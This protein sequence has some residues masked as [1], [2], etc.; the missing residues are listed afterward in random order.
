MPP[1]KTKPLSGLAKT[2]YDNALAAKNVAVT[3][4]DDT[5]S[6]FYMVEITLVSIF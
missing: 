6:L 1:K 4:A 2:R 3:T 5:R